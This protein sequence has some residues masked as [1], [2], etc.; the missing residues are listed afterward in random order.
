VEFVFDYASAHSNEVES[1]PCEDITIFV[2]KRKQLDSFFYHEV[3]SDH[4][5]LI[6]YPWVQRDSF[7]FALRLDC[8]FAFDAGFGLGCGRVL[9]ASAFCLL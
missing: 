4:Y 6:W 2:Q 8:C 7:C 3:L 1:L 9:E 5:R